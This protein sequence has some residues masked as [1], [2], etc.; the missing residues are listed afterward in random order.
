MRG[1]V[2]VK[3]LQAGKISDLELKN[4]IMFAPMGYN[5]GF[6]QEG[7]DYFVERAKGG[8][9][10][11]NIPI[12]A[13]E[14]VE[15]RGVSAYLDEKSYNDFVKI[16]DSIHANGAK[17]CTQIIPGYGAISEDSKHYDVPVSASAVP[18]IYNPDLI[19]H[20]LT[21]EEIKAIQDGFRE[22][23]K[24]VKKSGVDAIEIHAYG[25][26]LTDQFLTA[27]WNKRV[28]KYG[29]N[30][31]GR[32]T[33]LLELIEIVK[34]ECGEKYP[35]IVKYS[36]A[37]YM[38][39]EG[40]RRIEEGIEL[41]KILEQAG[42]HLLHV[43]AGSHGMRWYIAMPPVYQ[44][45]QVYQLRA[46]DAVK[47]AVSIPVASNGKLGY[48]EK[49]ETA[50]EQGK[51]DFLVIGRGLLADPYLPT[52]L[53]EGRPDD[54]IP[55]IGCNDNCIERVSANKHIA[56]TVNPETGREARMK[57]TPAK[58]SKKIL[59][60]GGGPAGMSAAI[61]AKR[62]G[63]SVELWE[64][65][66]TLGGLLVSAGR[67]SFKLEIKHLVDYYRTQLLKL[68]IKIKYSTK[69]SPENI[70]QSGAD[71]VIVA[72]GSKTLIPESIPGIDGDNVVTGI[73]AMLD[74]CTL[75]ENIAMI[76]G[77]LVGCETALHLT[78][79]G[80]KI[81]LIEMQPKL[82]PEPIFVMNEM[83]LAGMVYRDPNITVHTNTKLS[84]IN[85][86]SIEVEKEGEKLT[87]ACETVVLAMG[88]ESENNF[89]KELEGRIPVYV[90]GDC[91]SPR[92]IGDTVLEARQAVLSISDLG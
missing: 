42:V 84:K 9:G 50:L 21:I 57:I 77:G 54:I 1:V 8:A 70:L 41:S 6:T 62:M 51:L 71:A 65:T 68:G 75:G 17:A 2:V 40:Y 3:I 23:V 11:I 7:H 47:K 86:D 61:D 25:G 52:K 29:G 38:D 80:K 78:P 30:V 88:L 10:L 15:L 16:V 60:V 49:A 37:H 56:C 73:D 82:L 81:K 34:E 72:T 44:Q 58:Q 28:D 79:R 53:A 59:V 20:E 74:R 48:V 67:P 27:Y 91:M 83:M 46:A 26:Y 69:A 19:C 18:S 22:T 24:L 76:G 87:I 13:T 12:F 63:H 64:K 90:I 14:A 45:E 92:K 35:I 66:T 4:R 33:F 89:T 36:P 55:C 85:P 32:A 31:K 39:L 43:D 5:E